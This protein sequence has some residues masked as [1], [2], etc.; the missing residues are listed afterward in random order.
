[1]IFS[2][3]PLTLILVKLNWLRFTGLIIFW[4]ILKNFW[5]YIS[6]LHWLFDC[7]LCRFH[8]TGVC[9]GWTSPLDLR[10]SF[11]HVLSNNFHFLG[12]R[13]YTRSKYRYLWFL[14]TWAVVEAE[15]IFATPH[16]FSE[17]TKTKLW[18]KCN[19]EVQSE[20][21]PVEQ[22]RHK[23]SQTTNGDY[24]ISIMLPDCC[25]PKCKINNPHCD[26]KF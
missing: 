17:S 24:Y 12:S 13:F 19:G 20:Y 1:M 18:R 2:L 3:W 10:H 26:C 16:N 8:S 11:V 7:F 15:L 21:T 9:S 14:P 5:C 25:L 6:S 4:V 23:S 22:K